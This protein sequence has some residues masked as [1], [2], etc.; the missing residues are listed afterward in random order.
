[1]KSFQEHLDIELDEALI[2]EAGD[3]CTLP[4]SSL[5]SKSMRAAWEK[6]CGDKI[7]KKKRGTIFKTAAKRAGI[8]PNKLYN[9]VEK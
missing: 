7:S 1:M 8:S 3:M 5:S 6:K 9:E 4:K 2:A